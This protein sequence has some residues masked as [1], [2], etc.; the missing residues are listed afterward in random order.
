MTQHMIIKISIFS[1]LAILLNIWPSKVTEPIQG[2][3]GCLSNFPSFCEF[4][5]LI[6]FIYLSVSNPYSRLLP[7][8][9]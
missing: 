9:L 2:S 4:I 6:I 3:G 7:L 8:C 1:F 5:Y